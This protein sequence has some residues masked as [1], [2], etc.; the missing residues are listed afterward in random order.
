MAFSASVS[1]PSPNIWVWPTGAFRTSLAICPAS[2]LAPSF[3]TLH[4]NHFT[5]PPAPQHA[6]G[7]SAL[8]RSF[9]LGNDNT[10]A[11]HPRL[12]SLHRLGLPLNEISSGMSLCH[13]PHSRL[14]VT[15]IPLHNFLFPRLY[16]CIDTKTWRTGFVFLG[17]TPQ[18]LTLHLT[19]ADTQ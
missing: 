1:R 14:S 13:L 3:H 2:C 17:N 4:S 19:P 8:H 7:A 6:L 5:S 18:C 16:F 15:H 11:S 12:T 10:G 9:L